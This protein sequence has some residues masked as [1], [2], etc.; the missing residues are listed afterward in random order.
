MSNDDNLAKTIPS[1]RPAGSGGTELSKTFGLAAPPASV[2]KTTAEIN[3]VFI[4]HF[5][6]HTGATSLRSV[7]N[8]CRYM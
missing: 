5:R 8:E 3:D 4:V 2:K 7:T 1:S 6:S